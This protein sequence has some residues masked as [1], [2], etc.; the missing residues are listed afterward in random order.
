M[1]RSWVILL[2]LLLLQGPSFAQVEPRADQ[3]LRDM[4]AYLASQKQLSFTV[5][6]A[7]DEEL[8]GRWLE[9]SSTTDIV[10]RRPDAIC[11]FREG[12]KGRTF[13]YYN[14]QELVIYSPDKGYYS[15]HAVSGDIPVMLDHAHQK[16]GMALPVADFLFPQPYDVL[17]TDLNS[18]FY[19]GLRKV[20]GVDCHHLF[21]LTNSGLEWQIWIEAGRMRVPRKL[22]L[23]YAQ[24]P[25]APQYGAS[26]SNWDFATPI[27]PD[28]FHFQAPPGSLEI[29]SPT[30]G[31]K[32]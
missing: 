17:T 1:R 14:G 3:V 18:G 7:Y 12:D 2:L 16:L 19:A 8:S 29:E 6:A 9:Y 20:E 11:A 24:E 30:K 25:G 23:R 21:F 32:P 26:F 28:I 5:D 13:S 27:A 10:L 4:S 15:R 22:L 31:A